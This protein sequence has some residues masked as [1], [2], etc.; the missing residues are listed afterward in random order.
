MLYVGGGVVN[1]SGAE[2]APRAR[3]GG[4]AS[5][6]STTLMAQGRVPG[7]ARSCSAAGPACTGASCAN[8]TLNRADVA[9]RRRARAS[10]IASRATSTASPRARRSCTRHRSERDRQDTEA[11][12]SPVVGAARALRSR[13]SVQAS[14]GPCRAE[15]WLARIAALARAHPLAYDTTSRRSSRRPCIAAARRDAARHG[16]VVYT[17]GVGQHQMWAMQ[18]LRCEPAALVRH[19][20]RARTMGFGLPAAIGARA[21]RPDVTVVCVDGDGSFQ[22]TLQELATAVAEQ[23][24]GE[25][26]VISTTGARHGRPVAGR[27]STSGRRSQVDV[28]GDRHRLR[29]RSRAASAPPAFTV[30]TLAELDAGA[31]GRPTTRVHDRLDVRCRAGRG[32]PADRSARRRATEMIEWARPELR[33]GRQRRQPA[34]PRG[35]QV[36]LRRCR[37]RACA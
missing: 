17:T 10:T 3:R 33:A 31:D 14:W 37:R 6:S 36:G 15:V 12:T 21:A 26:I 25:R 4:A 19:L 9:D 5:R 24:P 13:R 23:T 2:R 11:P 16:D 18:Y 34:A 30:R 7:G 35:R 1:A 8:S 20:G 28:T 27:R 22:M 32:V 29:A